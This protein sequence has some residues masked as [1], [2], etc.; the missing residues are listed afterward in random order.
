M[1]LIV[2]ACTLLLLLVGTDFFN[3]FGIPKSC[4]V[5]RALFRVLDLIFGINPVL[6]FGQGTFAHWVVAS[7]LCTTDGRV[8]RRRQKRI[9]ACL[10]NT[11]KRPY[12]LEDNGDFLSGL[13]R[14]CFGIH[15]S[16]MYPKY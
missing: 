3:E 7:M 16:R 2:Q 9:R 13:E 5:T 10:E 8:T 1:L 15:R 4:N 12:D 11:I 6:S 14:K